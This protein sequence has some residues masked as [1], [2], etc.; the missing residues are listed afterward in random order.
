M[1]ENKRIITQTVFVSFYS[2][3]PSVDQ[4]LEFV[5]SFDNFKVTNG[6]KRL[7]IQFVLKSNSNFVMLFVCEEFKTFAKLDPNKIA[8]RDVCCLM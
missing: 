7:W 8:G 1:I 2:F 5:L 3:L 6:S 4:P